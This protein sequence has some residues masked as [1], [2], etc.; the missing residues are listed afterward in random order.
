[1]CYYSCFSSLSKMYWLWY[2][3]LQ[4]SW[5]LSKYFHL[6]LLK[7]YAALFLILFL[8]TFWEGR[9]EKQI[10]ASDV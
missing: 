7:R 8:F 5:Q 6:V 1:M 4:K 3:Q 2:F 9:K 10:K